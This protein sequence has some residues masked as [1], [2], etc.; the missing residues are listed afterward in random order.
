MHLKFPYCFKPLFEPKRIKSLSGGRGSAKS[1]SVARFML[2]MAMSKKG[3]G[4]C[5]RE[6]QKSIADSVYKTLVD[7]IEQ[8]QLPNFTI[9]KGYIYNNITGYDF[10]FEGIRNNVQALKSIKGVTHA[11][12]EEAHYLTK[13]SIDILVPTVREENSEL[14]FTYNRLMQEDPVWVRYGPN[15]DKSLVWYLHTTYRNN[16]FFPKVLDQE[17]LACLRDYPNDYPHIWEGEPKNLGGSM[18]DVDWFEWTDNI[19]KEN[20]FDYR[21][22]VADTAYKEKEVTKDEKLTDP[23]FHVFG[24]FGVKNKKL[25]WIDM[26]RAQLKAVD[27]EAWCVPFIRPKQTYGF[28]YSWIEPKGHGIY[29]NQR[30]PQIRLW[31]P[32]EEKLK[33]TLE[34]RLDKVERASNSIAMIDR[35]DKNVIINTGMEPKK[36]KAIR[37]EL[38]FFPNGVHDDTEDVLCDAI[39]IAFGK[40]DKIIELQQLLGRID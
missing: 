15:A 8:E 6:L 27:V 32:D 16:P 24:Y 7:V 10:I 36:I 5:T 38:I 33:E 31:V 23:D 19:P 17:R 39:K 29:L 30:F 26:I 35:H 3:R 13:D 28:R 20:E 21:F 37:E 22:I 18:Y 9:Q 2:V 11:W 25:Y 4:L 12:C 40:P 14:I 1:E 34:R